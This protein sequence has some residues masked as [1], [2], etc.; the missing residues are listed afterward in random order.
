MVNTQIL[1]VIKGSGSPINDA[2]LNVDENQSHHSEQRFEL[3]YHEVPT[4]EEQLQL[5]ADVEEKS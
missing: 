3:E 5:T 4:I 2:S 1:Y